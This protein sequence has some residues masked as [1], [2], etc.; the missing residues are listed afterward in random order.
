MFRVLDI[1]W[2]YFALAILIGIVIG[3]LWR[4]EGGFLAGYAFLLLAETLLIRE[5]SNGSH[6][7]PELFWSWKTWKTQK[8]QI[9]TNV[10]MF[11]P[12]GVLAGRLWKWRG[13]IVAAGLSVVIEVLQLISQRGLMEYDDIIHNCLGAAIG[14]CF[15]VKRRKIPPKF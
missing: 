14:V 1:P 8:N 12:F 6:F 7:Q 4:F 5:V 9:M 2:W 3:K 11:I 13:L 15:M 10:I